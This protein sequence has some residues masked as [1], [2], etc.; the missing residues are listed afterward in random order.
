MASYTARPLA[1]AKIDDAVATALRLEEIEDV[2]ALTKLLT[3]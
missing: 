2:T 1:Q 3:S